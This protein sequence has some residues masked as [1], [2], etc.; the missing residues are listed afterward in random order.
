MTNRGSG[1][2]ILLASQ[3]LLGPGLFNDGNI[4]PAHPSTVQSNNNT[5]HTH[6]AGAICGSPSVLHGASRHNLHQA[7]HQGSRLALAALAGFANHYDLTQTA[8]V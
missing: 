7:F 2:Y 1:I 8:L 5:Y 3:C 6:P 4:L